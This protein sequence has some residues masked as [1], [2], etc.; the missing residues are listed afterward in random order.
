MLNISEILLV[1]G[2]EKMNIEKQWV[3]VVR[4]KQENTV[5]SGCSDCIPWKISRGGAV[6]L[7]PGWIEWWWDYVLGQG[8]GI[9]VRAWK[10]QFA[11]RKHFLSLILWLRLYSYRR[12]V[13]QTVNVLE[14]LLWLHWEVLCLSSTQLDCILSPVE[15]TVC[16]LPVLRPGPLFKNRQ[17][18]VFVFGFIGTFF[19]VKNLTYKRLYVILCHS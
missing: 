2:K 3:F 9:C 18:F 15:R 6:A 5:D 4:N 10:Y 11:S 12:L 1:W 13:E 19:F 14:W 17:W 8:S 16:I 7:K